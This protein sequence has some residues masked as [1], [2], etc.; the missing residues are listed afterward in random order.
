MTKWQGNSL[1]K[2]GVK[3]IIACVMI[4]CIG[5]TPAIQRVM[6]FR[7][8]AVDQVNRAVRTVEGIAGKSTNVAKR[9][10]HWANG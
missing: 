2:V 6:V 4:L 9:A 1:S 7:S 8:L 5:P 3:L 10:R